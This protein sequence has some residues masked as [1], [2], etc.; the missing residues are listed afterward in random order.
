MKYCSQCGSTVSQ[1][2]PEQDDR[3][4]YICDTCHY[5]HYENPRIVVCALPCYED[6]VLMCKRAIEPRYGLW[7]LPGGFMENDETTQDAAL[8]ETWEEARANISIGN[9]YALYN[10]PH[11]NQVHI[12]YL[13]QLESTDYAAGMES[14]QVE[15]LTEQETPWDEIA[16]TAVHDALQHYF[17]DRRS[18]HF[19]MHVADITPK[20]DNGRLI[21]Q[22]Q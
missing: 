6:K 12:F 8:R 16:F 9:M 7:T 17:R 10:L 19:P 18:Q 1:R 3:P 14:L 11:I 5:I 13:A 21:H 20:G 4:R 22:H 2:I 15:L